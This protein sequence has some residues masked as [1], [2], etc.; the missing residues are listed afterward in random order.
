MKICSQCH[1]TFEDYEEFCD[2]DRTKLTACP[3]PVQTPKNTA[4]LFEGSFL[5]PL[6]TSRVFLGLLSLA[7]VISSALLIGYY[8]A[9]SQAKFATPETS[10]PAQSEPQLSSSSE[11][12]STPPLT[13]T[14]GVPPAP[15]LP[16]LTSSRS[17]KPAPLNLRKFL[18]ETVEVSPSHSSPPDIASRSVFDSN[19]DI[20]EAPFSTMSQQPEAN[21]FPPEEVRLSVPVGPQFRADEPGPIK[22]DSKPTSSLKKTGRVLKKTAS[23]LTKPLER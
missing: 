17:I 19:V 9:A 11:S 14:A 16:K 20:S 7:G 8:D 10:L 4:L 1:F 3:E 15:A 5:I 18:P 23:T 13:G 6:L 21:S 22:K 2:F 12:A